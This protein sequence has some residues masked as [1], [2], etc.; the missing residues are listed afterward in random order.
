MLTTAAIETMVDDETGSASWELEA[1]V[2]WSSAKECTFETNVDGV[3]DT[4]RF[5]VVISKTMVYDKAGGAN[6]ELEVEIILSSV[7]ECPFKGRKDMHVLNFR[8]C[9]AGEWQTNFQDT[10]KMTADV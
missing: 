10:K 3:D 5:H 4:G 2:S 8:L 6:W 7:Q 9:R 1:K